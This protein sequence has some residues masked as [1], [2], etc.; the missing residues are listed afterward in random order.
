MAGD[1][2][3]RYVK[4]GN[5]MGP[6]TIESLP[7]SKEQ[8]EKEK[9]GLLP[10]ADYPVKVTPTAIDPKTGEPFPSFETTK[11]AVEMARLPRAGRKTKRRAKKAKKTRGRR[12]H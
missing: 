11:G 9:G 6:A 10:P 2:R 7:L 4:A 8:V 5:Y 1:A 3:V 12:R